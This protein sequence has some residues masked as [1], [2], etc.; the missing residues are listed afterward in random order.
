MWNIFKK[1]NT[2]KQPEKN[3]PKSLEEI[4]GKDAPRR[5]Y[6]R[7]LEDFKKLSKTDSYTEKS[8][9]KNFNKTVQRVAQ[10]EPGKLSFSPKTDLAH[11]RQINSNN[12]LTSDLKHKNQDSDKSAKLDLQKNKAKA[13]LGQIEEPNINLNNDTVARRTNSTVINGSPTDSPITTFAF[14]AKAFKMHASN[15]LN[16][17]SGK[18]YLTAII[19]KR[20]GKIYFRE[21]AD[22]YKVEAMNI[23]VASLENETN[24][25]GLKEIQHT[26][27][28]LEEDKMLLSLFFDKHYLLILFEQN[29]V[30]PGQM[31]Y[32]VR[33]ELEKLYHELIENKKH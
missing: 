17:I 1:K 9:S 14:D 28:D 5:K 12:K 22:H 13:S 4:L 6:P 33:P 24:A 20:D 19:G 27:I 30:T 3:K 7:R 10:E 15:I 16:Q 32:I 26:L 2:Q 18:V 31:L 29:S 8:I 21:G 23:L 11:Q 25:I